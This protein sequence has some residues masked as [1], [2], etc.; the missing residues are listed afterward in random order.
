MTAPLW[1][2][3]DIRT[4]NVDKKS[5]DGEPAVRLVNYTDVY[6]NQTISSDMTLMEA[7]ASSDH[8]ARFG[9]Q[10]NDIIITKDSESPDDIGVPSLVIDASDD[11]VCAYHLSLLRPDPKHGNARYLYW[12][13]ESDLA[14]RHWFT[15]SFGVTRYAILSGTI[16]R[17]GVP[18]YDFPTQKRIA[19]YLDRETGEIDAMLAKMDELTE[20]LE[21]RRVSAIQRATQL[22]PD[23]QRWST[24]PT[25]HLFGSI[26]SGTTPKDPSHYTESADGVPWVTTS[27]LRETL[28]T[29]TTK[30]VTPGAIAAVS[31]LRVHPAGS[32]LIAM[33]G[34][35]I[36]RLGTLGV[37]A[38]MNQACCAFSDP[39]GVD[40]RF[41]YYTLWGQ[42]D[43]IILLA[44]G[45][46]Q[47]NISQTMLRRWRVPCP[48]LDEQ[49][50][51]ADHLDEVTG[52]IDQ[53]LAKTAELK[54]LLIE[55]RAALITDV[56]T[57]KK[58]V[59]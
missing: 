57:G 36:G 37:D 34:A 5:R 45:G 33:Y 13:L 56:V 46:G 23:G 1:A 20:T 26:G 11:M 8:I 50:R 38:T 43:D 14:K 24:V 22:D 58:Q 9:V 39:Q 27:E 47:P 2:L 54:A 59:S 30:R 17:L 16:A 41:F 29:E 10:V 28:I 3:A 55:R 51:I 15:T 6:Y 35:T 7:T 32:I 4:S 12:V 18:Y 40:M 25:A 31:S 49:R 19:D 42:R 44:V 21:A 48:P 53:M 52:K